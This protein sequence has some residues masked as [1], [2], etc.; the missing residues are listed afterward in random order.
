MNLTQL[1]N[2]EKAVV[3]KI[4]TSKRLKARLNKMGLKEGDVI[5]FMRSAPFLSPLQVKI[6][7]YY[8]AIRNKDAKNIF[9]ERK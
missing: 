6:N 2:G 7:S 8:L 4:D 5:T 1:K 3:Y 9:V